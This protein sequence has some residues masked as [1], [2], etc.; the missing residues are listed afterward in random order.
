MQ[1]WVSIASDAT[2]AAALQQAV[3]DFGVVDTDT[4]QAVLQIPE[5]AAGL[6]RAL[7]TALQAA[8]PAAES[9]IDKHADEAQVNV[10]T[11]TSAA[12]DMVDTL[13]AEAMIS[14]ALCMVDEAKHRERLTGVRARSWEDRAELGATLLRAA[15]ARTDRAEAARQAAERSA[16]AERAAKQM[17]EHMLAAEA[18]LADAAVESARTSE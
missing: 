16:A 11:Q 14:E 8:P 3:V 1:M 5:T 12:D 15:E 4:L 6:A 10:G 18:A 7:C 17:A 13:V 9:M 2:C